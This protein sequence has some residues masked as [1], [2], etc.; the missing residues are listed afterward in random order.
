MG[1]AGWFIGGVVVT[2]VLA[3]GAITY[4]FSGMRFR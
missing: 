2:S 3:V 1:A 4:L